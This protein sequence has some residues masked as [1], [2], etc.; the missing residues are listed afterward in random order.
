MREE[1]TRCKITQKV[2]QKQKEEDQ[3]TEM[4]EVYIKEVVTEFAEC[5]QQ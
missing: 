1:S 5:P 3:T 2:I 4:G